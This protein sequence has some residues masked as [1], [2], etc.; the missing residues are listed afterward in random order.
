M[1]FREIFRFELAYQIRRPWVWLMFGVMFALCFL[2]TR[3]DALADA[4]YDEFL[5]NSPFNIAVTTVVGGLLWLVVAPVIAGE[6]AARDVA[7]RMDPLV[8]TVRVSKREYLGGRFLAAFTINAILLVAVQLGILLAVYS[9]GVNA[10]VVGPFR[11]AAYLTAYLFLSL[12]NAFAGTAIQFALALR[13]GRPMAGYLGSLFFVFMGFFVASLL[14]FRR[15]LGTL[16]DPVGIRFIVEDIAHL[17]TTIEKSRR[18]L[19][20]EGIVLQNRLVW[21]GIA[22]AVLAVTYLRFRFAHRGGSAARRWWRRRADAHA[23]EPARTGVT[24]T[25]PVFVPH[26][27]RSFGLAAHARQ[28]VAIAWAS[29]RA[30]AKS[31]AGLGFFVVIPLLTIPVL[32]DQMVASGTPLV[33]V[34]GQVLKELTGPLTS[35]L[36][37]WVI[38]PLLCVFFAGELLW[39]ERETGLDEIADAAPVPDWVP[40]AGK[41]LGLGLVLAVFLALLM[42]A[43]MVSQA[44]LGYHH[45]ELGLYVAVLFGLQL[46][47]YLL[48]V[49]LALA[50]HVIVGQKYA[51]HL[52]AMV[53]YAVIVLAPA[54]GIEHNLLVYGAG[55]WVTFTEMRGLGPFIEPWLWFKLYWAAWALL[56]AVAAR[57]FWLRGRE[58]RFATRVRLARRR[59][60]GATARTAAIAIVLILTLGGFVF[61]NTNVLNAYETEAGVAHRRAEYERRYRRYARIPQPH[62][63][64]ASVHI[65]IH[66]ARR[67]VDIRGSYRLVN[68]SRVP[69]D[70]IHVAT[71]LT[72]ETKALEFDRPATRTLLDDDH[73]H[74]TYKLESPLPPGGSTRLDFVVHVERR[75]FREGG[76]DVSIV[77]NGTWFTQHWFPA[78]GYQPGRELVLPGDRREQGLAARR[79]IPSLYDV[80][81]RSGREPGMQFEAVLSTDADQTAVAPGALRRTWTKDGRRYFHYSTDGPIGSEWA[82]ASAKYALHEAR[83]KDVVIRVFH[84][85][86]HAVHPERMARSIQASLDYLTAQIGPYPYRHITVLEVPG[87][88]IG[89]HADAAMLTHGEG[90]TLMN[91]EDAQTF[92]FPFAIL[93]HETAHQW[94]VP[95]APVEGAPV[96]AESVATYY[97]IKVVEHAKGPDQVRRYMSFLRQPYPIAPIRRGEPLLRGLDPW[98]SYRKGPYALYALS[99]TIGEERVNHAL[100]RLYELHEPLDAPLATT[101]D[102]YRQLKAVTPASAQYLLH[103]LFEVNTFWQLRTERVAAKQVPSGAWQV[104]LGVQARKVVVDEA[105]VETELPMDEPVEIGIFARAEPGQGE[106]SAPL[107]LEQHRIRSGPQTITVTVPRQ[108]ALAGID[109]RHLLDWEEKE[110]DDNVEGV[111]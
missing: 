101:L 8:Y 13:T 42:T 69:I 92:D 27:P 91:V 24:A 56:L 30:I 52:V 62:I 77:P 80:E 71:P 25:A 70:V 41:L 59:L 44:I 111:Q 108:P 87:D 84:H 47:E 67:E 32:I 103:D 58:S 11:P 18:L 46:P 10:E 20:F 36:S 53:V 76:A 85:P 29:F 2:M 45:F 50:V 75:G 89:M 1:K 73:G 68:R 16:L 26:A 104:T 88:G 43:G 38:V 99:E 60:T 35:E 5:V 90:V 23:P 4:L 94:A 54:F 37:R 34:T 65:D 63:A 48:F 109:P 102:L 95:I 51:G 28:T 107:H 105:G 96:V 110:D 61:Y 21:L 6:A 12:P 9:P 49:V 33:P 66:P 86:A 100:R 14:L 17:W 98:M 31:R 82:F 7:T 106:L 83:W 3:D 64:A 74:R 22:L 57:L 15:G 39:R 81:A 93:A 40:L 72:V 79:V 78:I 19:A 97:A 55:P